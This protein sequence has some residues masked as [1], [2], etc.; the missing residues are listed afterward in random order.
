MGTRKTK[1]IKAHCPKCGPDR[2]A[3]VHGEFIHREYDEMEVVWA[4]TTYRLLQCPACEA[5]Y[6]Q[7]DEI[8]SEHY[9]HY[10]HAVTGEEVLE[11]HHT[12]KHYPS[13]ARRER[14]KWLQQLVS[15]DFEFYELL[16]DIYAA[17]D[18]EIGRLA[19]IGIRTAFDKASELLKIDPAKT[20]KAKLDELVATGKIGADERDILDALTDA[21]G[22]AAHRGWKPSSEELDTMMSSIENFVYR[23]F[24][25][26]EAAK[27]LKAGV[28][29]KQKLQKVNAIVLQP[30][31]SHSTSTLKDNET[32]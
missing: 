14:P 7:S 2:W 21:G 22:A 30:A 28:P 29:A 11:Y 26:G 8:F 4:E 3:T 17:L 24:I 10:N 27:K 16:E 18:N 12:I 23:T 20:F 6:Y 9:D 5:V 1:K 15:L 32:P 13:P 25:L 19:A 31:P